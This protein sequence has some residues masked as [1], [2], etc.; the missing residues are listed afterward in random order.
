MHILPAPQ[1]GDG[2]QAGALQAQV[3]RAAAPGSMRSDLLAFDNRWVGIKNIIDASHGGD[4]FQK[5]ICLLVG[6]PGEVVVVFF[7]EF[8]RCRLH[9]QDCFVLGFLSDHAKAQLLLIFEEIFWGDPL[10]IRKPQQ[11]EISYKE[12]IPFLFQVRLEANKNALSQ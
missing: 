5:S 4:D 1:I 2:L 8:E 6:A 11:E 10:H 7:E 12:P 3:G 9:G